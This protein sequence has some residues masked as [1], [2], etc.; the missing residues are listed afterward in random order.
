MHVFPCV[1][2]QIVTKCCLMNHQCCS[3]TCFDEFLTRNSVPT[4]AYLDSSAML[5]DKTIGLWAVDDMDRLKS[6]NTLFLQ[7]VIEVIY[8][9]FLLLEVIRQDVSQFRCL[10]QYHL[11]HC[12]VRHL[13]LALVSCNIFRLSI[14]S[15]QFHTSRQELSGRTGSG[16]PMTRYTQCMRKSMEPCCMALSK[17]F[18]ILCSIF[19]TISFFLPVGWEF[20][21]CGPNGCE[22]WRCIWLRTALSP[23]RYQNGWATDSS[24][25]SHSP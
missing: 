12:N 17:I 18:M 16:H 20:Q 14:Q 10:H 8:R 11:L 7:I 4:V 15:L 22:L 2:L 13:Q 21:G 1:V 3:L 24:C 23:L 19:N 9:L 5:N 25:L 6:N